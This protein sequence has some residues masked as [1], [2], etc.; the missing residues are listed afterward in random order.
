V[1]RFKIASFEEVIDEMILKST[2]PFS[3]AVPS[4]HHRLIN[5][6]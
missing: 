1:R 2:F 5:K 4:F 6:I 3:S